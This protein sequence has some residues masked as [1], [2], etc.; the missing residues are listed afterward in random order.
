VWIAFDNLYVLLTF[1]HRYGAT[2]IGMVVAALYVFICSFP[3]VTLI[4]FCSLYGGTTWRAVPCKYVLIRPSL[5]S[6]VQAMYYFTNQNDGWYLKLT[7]R[8][9]IRIFY[10]SWFWVRSVVIFDTV[11]Q[12]LIT[13]TGG[14]IS[15]W[16][17]R[18]C[19]VLT[20]WLQ[21]TRTLSRTGEI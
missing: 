18:F 19:T 2:F 7:V 12:A 3:L 1:F 13:H 14:C 4:Y 9:S 10:L 16:S 11:H 15:L 6:C 20:W 17:Q 8:S 21:S 5:V